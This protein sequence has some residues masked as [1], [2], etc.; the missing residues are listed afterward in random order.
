MVLLNPPSKIISSSWGEKN[1]NA[2][3]IMKIH[4]LHLRCRGRG[5][6][7]KLLFSSLPSLKMYLGEAISI[8]SKLR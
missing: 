4:L 6:S 2:A 5:V 3:L 7:W 1:A 8:S